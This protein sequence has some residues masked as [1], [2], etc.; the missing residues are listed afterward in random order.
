MAHHYAWECTIVPVASILASGL[1]IIERRPC[2]SKILIRRLGAL[3]A[4]PMD[5]AAIIPTHN[6]AGFV[7]WRSRVATFPNATA[8]SNY[9]GR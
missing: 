3:D 5:I 2:R 1:T 8:G 6:S 9:R 7:A 4:G